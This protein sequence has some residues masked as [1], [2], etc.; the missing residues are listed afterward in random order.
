MIMIANTC[1]T[2]ILIGLSF[3]TGSIQILSGQSQRIMWQT[4]QQDT[5]LQTTCN[6]RVLDG[7][8]TP[9]I[10]VKKKGS[11]VQFIHTRKESN[12]DHLV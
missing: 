12:G 2:K 4:Y 9:E 1:F 7:H 8:I 11:W 3:I 5:L 6:N 10:L